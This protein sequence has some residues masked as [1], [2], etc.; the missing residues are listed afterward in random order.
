VDLAFGPAHVGV[1][2][3]EDAA[4]E[5]LAEITKEHPVAGVVDHRAA[6]GDEPFCTDLFHGG[7]DA[8]GAAG[9]DCHRTFAQ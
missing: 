9:E 6:N 2:I 3:F 5:R 1:D 4:R 7:D 8:P